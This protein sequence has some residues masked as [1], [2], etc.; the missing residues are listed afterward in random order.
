VDQSTPLSCARAIHACRLLVAAYKKGEESHSVAWE[1]VDIA[2][3]AAQAALDIA[4]EIGIK[5]SI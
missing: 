5:E 2:F 3:A 1:D 4:G